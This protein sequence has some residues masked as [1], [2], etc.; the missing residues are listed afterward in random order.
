MIFPA[1]IRE[2]HKFFSIQPFFSQYRLEKF[3][4]RS[5]ERVA[6]YV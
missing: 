5:L 1:F 4:P 2:V 6:G 3:H